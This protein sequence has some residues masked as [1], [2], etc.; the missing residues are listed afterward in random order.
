MIFDPILDV[1]RGKAVT[2]PPMDGA[3]KPNTALD[4]APV[5]LEIEAPDNLC[6]DGS[7]LLFSSGDMV[8]G[9]RSGQVEE[10]Q[11]FDAP[12]TA[13][14]ISPSGDIAVGLDNGKL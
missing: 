13:L 5:A 11:S 8:F 10:I 1:F 4:D 7:K 9:L 12:V 6:T 2:I 3:L 14:A